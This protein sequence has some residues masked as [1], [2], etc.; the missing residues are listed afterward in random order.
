MKK[1]MILLALPVCVILSGCSQMDEYL[2]KQM[3]EQSEIEDNQEYKAYQEYSKQGKLNQEGFYEENMLEDDVLD[4]NSDENRA[5]ETA[6]IVFSSN[7]YLDVKYF[8][9]ADLTVPLDEKGCDLALGDKIYARGE[10]NQSVAS[11]MYLFNGFYI[12]RYEE[13]NRE[14]IR[15]LSPTEDGFVMEVTSE[16]IGTDLSIEPIGIYQKRDISLRDYYVDNDGT[17]QELSETWWI[18]DRETKEDKIELNP[19]S[20]YIISYEYDNNEYFYVS[21]TP[22]CYYCNNEDG[23][24]IFPQKE[25][26]D[27]TEKAYSV[28]LHKYLVFDILSDQKREVRVN[29]GEEQTVKKGDALHLSKLKYGDRITIETDKEWPELENSVELVLV[30]EE[31]VGGKYRYILT[32]PQK[33]AEFEFNPEEY[34][35]EHGKITFK[36]FGEEVTTTQYLSKGHKIT[37]EGEADKGWQLKGKN[38]FI[39]VGDEDETKQQLNSIQF[40]K[41]ILAD[42]TLEQPEAGGTVTYFVENKEISSGTHQILCGTPITMNFEPWEGWMSNYKNGETYIVTDKKTQTVSINSKGVNE[43]FLEDIE[44]K[45]MLEVVLDKSVGENMQFEFA[46]SGLD[47]DDYQYE[48]GWFRRNYTVIKP[49]KIGTEKGITI[50]MNDRALQPNKAIKILVEKEDV[51][52]KKSSEYRL[53]NNLVENQDPISIYNDDEMGKSEIW[54]KTIK[55]TISV[56][57]VLTCEIPELQTGGELNVKNSNTMEVLQQGDILEGNEKVSVTITPPNGYYVSGKDTKN[58]IYQSTMKFSKY[59]SDIDQIIEE[60]PIEKYYQITLNEK[61]DYGRCSYSLSGEEVAGSILVKEGQKLTMEYTIEKSG[62]VIEGAKGVIFDIGKNDQKKKESIEVTAS[63]D[64][65]TINRDSFGI[66]VVEGE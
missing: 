10:V 36:C 33:G 26:R 16:D 27:E 61:D 65:Q 64:G 44:H 31:L 40:E 21:S 63:L 50:S 55:I 34:Q 2:E 7:S 9:D 47:K 11:N 45:P 43:C 48:D 54:Y 35:Y 51:N 15:E 37:Y 62:Y 25:A 58:D 19:V 14:R 29:G 13:G 24:V 52:K 28:E 12:Y 39:I 60:H 20:P 49:Q 5:L 6:H 38:H 18:D 23:I 32:V 3:M 57:D 1:Q 42:V 22:E 41:S 4:E 8:S 17:E 56:V 46:A 59:I 30:S 66:Q 53:V